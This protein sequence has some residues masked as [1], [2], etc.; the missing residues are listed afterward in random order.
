[1]KYTNIVTGIFINRP[2]R[3]IAIVNING[4]EETVHVKNTGR[5]RELL[6][7]GA[8]IILE[9]A[10]NADRKTKYSLI[11]VYKGNTLINIDSQVPNLVAYEG[12]LDGKVKKVGIP[13]F[14]KRE[15]KYGASR[16]D[17]Y[18]EDGERKGFIEVKGAT[19]EVDSVVKFPDAPTERGTKHI[20]E[21]INAVS[22]GFEAYLLFI[23]QMKGADHFEPNIVMDKAF[24]DALYKAS[25]SGVN[26]IAY[27]CNVYE[28]G[29]ELDKEVPC[30]I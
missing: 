11:A 13:A 7:P 4:T 25:V 29:I 9:K 18:F 2:N 10:R 21:L 8:R 26:I 27:Q 30:K 5:C 23:I 22:N 19:L 28:D 15:V 1:M 14:L 16:F 20:N 12:I 17:L 24:S 3:F 6:I